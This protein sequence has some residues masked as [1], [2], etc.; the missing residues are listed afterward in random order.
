M[1]SMT[2]ADVLAVLDALVG[3][4]VVASVGGGWGVDALLGRVTR[5]HADLDVAVDAA[6][7]GAAEAALERLGLARALDERPARVVWGDGRRAVDLHPVHWDAQGTGRQQ[8]LD[9]Q[10]FVY[11]PGSTGSSGLIG[12]RTVRCCSP[13]LQLAFHAHYEPRPHDRADM[14][15]LADA[16]GLELPP[17][18]RRPG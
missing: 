4:G 1:G 2:A 18:Y 3:S 11:P 9:G 12:G 7:L 6:Q 5:E 16:F 14:A 10:T 15:A 13:D 17:A 8:G